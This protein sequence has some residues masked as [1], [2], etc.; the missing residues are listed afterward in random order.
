M[1][2]YKTFN[3]GDRVKRLGDTSDRDIGTVMDIGPEG[4]DVLFDRSSGAYGLDGEELEFVS[5]P[6]KPKAPVGHVYNPDFEKDVEAVLT[7]V[8]E[9]LITKNAAY[10]NSALEPLQVFS[11]G[12]PSKSIRVRI[13][14]KLSRLAHG[15]DFENEDTVLDLLG[16]LVLL[17]ISEK[18]E[19]KAA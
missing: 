12:S 10:G 6:G 8:R 15:T 3:I 18:N 16:Y 4:Y 14:D 13:D 2:T 1:T 9:V 17:R 19:R 11:Q 5:A 7:R